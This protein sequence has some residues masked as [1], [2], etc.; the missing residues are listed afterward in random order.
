L[1]PPEL[2]NFDFPE[3][4]SSCEARFLTTQPAQALN[5]LNGHF[6]QQQSV[7]LAERV[8][9]DLPDQLDR[10]IA[11][12][13]ELALCRPATDRDLEIAHNVIRTM[14][15]KYQLTDD[16]ALSMYCLVVLNL[17]EFIYLD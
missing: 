14:H 16:R 17:N 7:K 8:S 10:Q 6:M 11:K 5:M 15:D 2:S 4:D 13:V 3:T 1:I 12:I 9:R